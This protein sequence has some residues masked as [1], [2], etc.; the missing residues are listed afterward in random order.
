[1]TSEQIWLVVLAATACLALL[2][3]LFS[4]GLAR[5]A[6]RRA[7]DLASPLDGHLHEQPAAAPAAEESAEPTSDTYVI[8]GLGDEPEP[9]TRGTHQAPGSQR[10][11][12]RLFADIVA[13]ETVVKAASWGHGLRRALSPE[14]RNRIRF[15][16]RQQTRQSRK[17][18][19]VEMREALREYRAR[20]GGADLPESTPETTIDRNEGAA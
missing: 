1:M 11:D 7:A 8:T 18:R 14:V 4:L 17:D 3:A 16:T 5:R 9:A 2:V 12:G 6:D 15:E 19:K 20:R 10:I 13:R